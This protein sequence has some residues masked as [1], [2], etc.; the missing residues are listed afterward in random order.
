MAGFDV[1]YGYTRELKG[2]SVDQAIERVT[3]ALKNEG[4]GVLTSIDVKDT[5]KKKLG[6]DFRRYTILGACN[7]TIAHKALTMSLGVG[8]VLPCNVC[9]FEGDQGEAVVQIIKP[10][11]MF[12]VV[13]ARGAEALVA[14]ADGKLR[15]ALESM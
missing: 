3:A 14:E 11:A 4:F 5:M 13:K 15:R 7:P 12:E 10:A 1:P 6:A 8:L 9:V 2:V